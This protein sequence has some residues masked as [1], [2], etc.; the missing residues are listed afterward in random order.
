M[1][2]PPLPLLIAAAAPLAWLLPNHYWPWPS[3]W[4]EG[5]ALAFLALAALCS[6]GSTQLARSWALFGGLALLTLAVQAASGHIFFVGDAWIAALYIASFIAATL[7]GRASVAGGAGP[8]A[9]GLTVLALGMLAAAI[10]STG[11]ALAQWTNTAPSGIWLVDLPPGGRPFGNVAQPNHLCTICLLGLAAAGLLRRQSQ[12]GRSGFWA[13]ALL[14]VLGM[15]LSGSRTGWLQMGML[16]LL[17]FWIGARS[18]AAPG[19]RGVLVLALLYGGLVLAWPDINDWLLL[20]EGR[21]LAETM[22]GGTRSLQWASLAEA[23]AQ[24][25]LSG[26]GWQQVSVAQVRLAEQRPFVGE[27]IEHAHNIVLDM[28]LWNGIPIGLTLVALALWWLLSRIWNCR[29]PA[30]VWLLI[31]ITGVATHGM[32]EYP[33]EYAYF[34]VPLGLYIGAVDELQQRP[35]RIRIPQWALRASGLALLLALAVVAQEYLQAEQ[36]N[37]LLR[38]ESARIGV[39][40]LQTPPPEL[41]VL[42]QL[43]AYLKF[44][45]TEARRGMSADEVDWMRKVSERFAYP[46]AMFRYALAA[47]L[48]GHPG[49][50]E[51][52][53]RRLCRMHPAQRCE[54]G[55]EAWK[56]LREKYPELQPVTF[57]PIPGQR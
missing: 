16:V 49:Q 44:A 12:C 15:V 19:R 27:H 55:A 23:I 24:R 7:V 45:H 42:T 25:P 40:G 2:S 13:A 3:A 52:T 54:E 26:Y 17:M 48:N 39:P 35:A 18:A 9:T 50:A 29:E 22:Q 32:L 28:L 34:L 47:G 20:Q 21:P 31:G 14:M 38:L 1:P 46:P 56:G 36:A 53:L 41:R 6:Q 51:L 4:L 57:P 8:S 43:G 37:R 5:V 11:I 10:A 33:L 30:A